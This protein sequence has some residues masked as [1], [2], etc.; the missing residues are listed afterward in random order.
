MGISIYEISID[1]T[2]TCLKIYKSNRHIAG[3]IISSLSDHFPTYYI[4]ECEIE[5]VVPK[6]FKTRLINDQTV[7]GFE[8]LLKSAPWDS[9][10]RDDPKITFDNFFEIIGNASDVAFPEVLV[11]PKSVKSF[12]NPWMSSGLLKSS[13]TKNRLFSKFKHKPSL[14]NSQAFKDYNAIFNK[15]KKAAKKAHFS[16][17]FE[18]HMTNLKKTWSLIRDVIGSRAKKRENLPN[19][20]KDNQDVL[21]NPLDIADGFNKYFAGIGPQLAEKIQP[22]PRSFESYMTQM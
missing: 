4:E 16:Q 9:V 21:N 22:S 3:I 19:F 2:S 12:R 13:Q 1:N 20:F 18:L 10:K 8:K 14:T 7:P 17:Q 15:C 6:P 5:K 11:K